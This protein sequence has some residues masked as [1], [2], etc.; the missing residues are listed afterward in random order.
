MKIIDFNTEYKP[1]IAVC[2]G[3]FDGLHSGHKKLIETAKSLPFE[4]ALFTIKSPEN[5][6]DILTFDELC[7]I[8]GCECVD[9]LIYATA[10]KDFFATEPEDFLNFFL[11]RFS[12]KAF[13]CGKDFTY[14]RD[15]KG[16][17]ET[18]KAFCEDKNIGVY[19]VDTIMNNGVK[20]SSTDIK[21]YLEQG[22]IKRAN[23]LLG[24]EFSVKGVVQAGR[25][26]GRK[27]GVRTANIT[28]PENKT[29]IKKG[30][31]ATQT[32]VGEAWYNSVSNYG[33]APTFGVENKL[34]E[35]HILGFV[36]D[37]YGNVI[38]VKFIDYI[39][40]NKTFY[41]EEELK[42]QLKKDMSY[43]D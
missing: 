25:E 43:Y 15:R 33:G 11:K 28:Y 2:L 37:V 31:Y 29:E 5:T 1:D 17:A 4:T 36:S 10:S 7:D 42:K 38:T 35:T 20:V 32:K 3:R 8:A 27:L 23:A 12:I 13:I 18:L 34:L 14:G 26:E 16:N 21:T 19:I 39:R 22:E 30:V 6:R 40:E 9:A 41:D 24:S